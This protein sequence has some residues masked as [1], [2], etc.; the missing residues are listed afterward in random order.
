[1]QLVVED[2]S[3]VETAYFLMS[4][5]NVRRQVALPWMSFCSDAGAPAAE[6]VFL[7][8]RPHP[9][10]YGSFAR[11]LGRYPQVA[12]TVIREGPP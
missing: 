3:R 8:D 10:A 4:E 11:L 6:G 7:Q 2:G 1:M 9:R 5:E 12:A